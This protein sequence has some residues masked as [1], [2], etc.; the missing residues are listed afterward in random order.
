MTVGWGGVQRTVNGGEEG[1]WLARVAI[2]AEVK[3]FTECTPATVLIVNEL[4]DCPP[5]VPSNITI[6][7]SGGRPNL[8]DAYSFG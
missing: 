4:L 8:F 7:V 1:R 6:H 5:P 2:R 3:S